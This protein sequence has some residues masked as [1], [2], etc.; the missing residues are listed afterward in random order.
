MTAR[1]QKKAAISEDIKNVL[2]E[3][4]GLEVYDIPH[5]IFTRE[6]NK[7][8]AQEVL[9]LTKDDII[10]LSWRDNIGDLTHLS[11]VDTGRIRI[12][13]HYKILYHMRDFILPMAN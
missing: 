9:T 6:A 3:L 7:G 11:K 2:E 10:V 13:L 4:R 5:K 12:L 8:G 1:D